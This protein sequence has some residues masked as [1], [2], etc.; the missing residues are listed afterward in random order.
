MGES[1]EWYR[2][3]EVLRNKRD[4][5]RYLILVQIAERQPAVSQSEI[6]ETLGITPQ[7]VSEYLNGLIEKEHVNKLGRGRWE[8][9][10]TGVDW[11][12]AQ[13]DILGDFTDHVW[14]AVI[15]QG[16][17]ETAIA[18]ETIVEGEEITL[19]MEEGVLT[20]KP[21]HTGPA[22]A[23]ALTSAE[24]GRDV[25]VTDISG[26]L[27]FTVGT[28]TIIEVPS[29]QAG[30]STVIDTN[31]II[32][33]TEESDLVGVAGPEALAVSRAANI[34]PDIQYGTHDGV[35]QAALKGM[36]VLLIAVENEI[37]KHAER[38]REFDISYEVV[39]SNQ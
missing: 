3:L 15:E 38:L 26:L 28:V 10:P 33:R 18:T 6:A 13:T 7:A 12:I 37:S 17:V 29:A 5:T 16:G 31:D 30:G 32:E 2:D 8:I 14:D 1:S 22:T 39:E 27:D 4:A 25:A 9:T 20:A 34:D 24:A 21:D 35:Q 19:S 23:R 11:L 36:N